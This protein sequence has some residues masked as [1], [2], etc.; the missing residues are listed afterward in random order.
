MHNEMSENWRSTYIFTASHILG[1]LNIKLI[2]TPRVQTVTLILCIEKRVQVREFKW[3]IG[4][5]RV[6][7]KKKKNSNNL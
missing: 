4:I 2:F 6:Y 7:F 3:V 5:G 1:Q